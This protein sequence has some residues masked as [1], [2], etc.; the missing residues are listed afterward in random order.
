ML[1]VT[2]G[3]LAFPAAPLVLLGALLTAVFVARRRGGDAAASA[4]NAVWLA[5]L[6]GLL[7]ARGV[8]LLQHAQAYGGSPLA[9]LDLRDGGWH[10]A[11][12]WFIAALVLGWRMRTA[13]LRGA[14]LA[15][16]LAALL[17]WGA[18][19]ALLQAL[20]R[21]PVGA[22]LPAV[23]LQPLGGADAGPARSLPEIVAGRP[24]VI[25]LWATWCGPC[26]AEMPLLAR[27]QARHGDVQFVFV[28][29]GEG[30][31]AVQ[32]WLAGS[33]LRLQGVWLDPGAALGPA[34]GSGGLPTTLFVDAEG[35]VVDAHMGMLNAAAL[36]ARLQSLQ[37]R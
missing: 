24:A 15:G 9:W 14:L 2:I 22:G 31:A 27:A 6:A 13:P 4:E 8:H 25:N 17:V 12:G 29:Q 3:P 19:Q 36:Q 26:R 33:G 21:G 11:S 18:G 30:A 23:A 5:A 20:G 37:G 32:A 1:A 34:V 7:A 28:N 35:R 10:A 16:A